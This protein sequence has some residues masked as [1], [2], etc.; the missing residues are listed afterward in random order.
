VAILLFAGFCIW[1]IR[2]GFAQY[3][4]SQPKT[5][6]WERV[7][8]ILVTAF[9]SL[10]APSGLLLFFWKRVR[11]FTRRTIGRLTKLEEERD[12][13]RSTSGLREDGTDEP[14]ATP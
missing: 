1:Q 9:V 10:V 8:T 5:E 11:D 12:R 14:G 6:A 13:G 7:M 3:L 2:L 4:A